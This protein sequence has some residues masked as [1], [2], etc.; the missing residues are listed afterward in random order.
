MT[1]RLIGLVVALA[2][3]AALFAAW[4]LWQDRLRPEDGRPPPPMTDALVER[5]AY[6]ARAGN[7][8]GCHS[9]PGQPAYAGGLAIATPFGTL[10]ASNLTPDAETGIGTWTAADMR[11]ALHQGR[12]KDGRRLY[13]AFPYPHYTLMSAEDSDA[14]HA[15][16][17]RQPAVH[18]PNAPHDLRYPY[19]TQWA[20]AV[21]RALYFEPGRF[22]PSPERTAEW[23]RGAYLVRGPGHCAACHAARN[24]LGATIDDNELGGG[25]IPMQ[26]WYAPSLASDREAGVARWPLEDVVALLKT[27][28][29]PRASVMGPMAEVVLGSTQHLSDADLR[30]MAAFLQG[31]PPHDPPRPKGKPADGAVLAR[32]ERLYGQHCKDCHGERGEGAAPAY[33]PLAG[34]RSVTLASPANALQAVLHGGFPP[35]TAGN[36]RPY[37]M[38]PFG[39]ALE[40]ADIAALLSF[41][42]QAWGNDAPA[43]DALAVQKAR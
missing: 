20:L 42:R 33:P 19:G 5:G 25:L 21:W 26:G 12:S 4:V 38:P 14:L 3:A 39:Q 15:F 23:N 40:D 1:R 9:L 7:C 29:S 43:V 2:L 37:G 34:N 24:R 27:G 18:R 31:L 6:L 36:P 16:L 30:A 13:P 8:A 11:R 28:L 17:M 10:V 32:G 41:I 35:A 22:E